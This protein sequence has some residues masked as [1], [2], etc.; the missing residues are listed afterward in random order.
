MVSAHF[1]H[2][3]YFIHHERR[4]PEIFDRRD[5]LSALGSVHV[6]LEAEYWPEL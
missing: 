1:A 2:S 5:R 6:D 4:V 3:T